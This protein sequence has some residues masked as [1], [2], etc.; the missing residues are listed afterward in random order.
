MLNETADPRFREP[1]ILFFGIGAQKA[2]TSWLYHFLKGHPEVSMSRLKELRYWSAIDSDCMQSVRRT[3]K[4]LKK[5][6]HR[7][8]HNTTRLGMLKDADP[9]HS[10]YADQLF[11]GDAGKKVAGE[12]TPAYALLS[13]K[14]FA[15]MASL[16]PDTRFVFM[17]R[18]P[19]DRLLSAARMRL[20]ETGSDGNTE[21]VRG[22]MLVTRIKDYLARDEQALVERSRYEKTIRSLE[23]VVTS[24]KIGLFFFEDIFGRKNTDPICDF[25]S[26]AR[27]PGD[28]DTV[29]NKGS[30]VE[31]DGEAQ[32]RALAKAA[33]APT[34][35]Y[36]EARFG[37][38]LPAAWRRVEERA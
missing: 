11:V 8:K 34:Y 22:D 15:T 38:R 36:M 28:F 14:T 37:D 12:I 26:I 3:R 33:L 24:D 16:N 32:C 5:K 6:P 10:S 17:M 1:E 2:G 9:T 31:G 35:D 7:A 25:L 4:S 23:A 27:V 21:A 20:R 30:A 29:V 18:D 19:A 13:E